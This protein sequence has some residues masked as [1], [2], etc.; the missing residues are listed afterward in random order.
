MAGR[1]D[2]NTVDYFPHYCTSGKTM[3][4]LENKYG[5]DGYATWFK[6]LE[7]LG[8][9]ENH[10]IDCRNI[11]DWEF[12]QAKARVTSE[13]LSDILNTLVNLDAINKELWDNKVIWSENFVENVSDAY[14]RRNNKCMNFDDLCKHLSVKCKHKCD[15]TDINDDKSTQT[16]VKKNKV[17]KN[18]EEDTCLSFEEFW[19]MYNKKEGAKPCR[20]KYEKI[21]EADR[22][23]IKETLPLY[24]NTITDKQFQKL[25]KT[26]LNNECWN[27]EIT[28]YK[29]SSSTSEQPSVAK[30]SDCERFNK[31]IVEHHPIL[32]TPNNLLQEFEYSALK[33]SFDEAVSL[34]HIIESK[35]KRQCLY[36]ELSLERDRREHNNRF[37]ITK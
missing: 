13:V 19:D 25:P 33:L 16:K 1:K 24:L 18:K 14:L 35:D 28:S 12:L 37:N 17:K 22:Q 7:M 6:I 27:D 3:Y 31:L 4:I 5:N 10:Y 2:K 29:K 30:I 9:S 36:M 26:Y 32:N 11:S 21:K 34:L 23:K 20:I 15:S 8:S